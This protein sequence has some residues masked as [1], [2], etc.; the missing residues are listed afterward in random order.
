MKS[1]RASA[2]L[3][4]CAIRSKDPYIGR[5][6][7]YDE[8]ATCIDIAE[9]EAEERVRWE[10]TRWHDPKE[11]LPHNDARVMCKVNGCAYA[12]FLVLNW[13]NNEWWIYLLDCEDFGFPEGTWVP[14]NGTVLS[15]REIHE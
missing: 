15:W 5:F 9:Q 11:E 2:C 7:R 12:E 1:K 10:L 4:R 8:A 14:F 13:Y 3:E 6:V